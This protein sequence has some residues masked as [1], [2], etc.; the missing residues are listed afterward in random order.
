MHLRFEAIYLGVISAY[1]L[2]LSTR[3]RF[4]TK[5]MNCKQRRTVGRGID[6]DAEQ[7]SI[8]PRASS[9]SCIVSACLASK[10]KRLR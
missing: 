1:M 3:M 2:F 4:Y 6:T 10:T 7:S 8:N 9:M 5:D